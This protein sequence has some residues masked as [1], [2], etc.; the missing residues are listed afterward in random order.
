MKLSQ[1]A[2]YGSLRRLMVIATITALTALPLAPAH[3]HACTGI[4][5]MGKDGTVVYGRTMEW[6]A[7]DLHSRV[8]IVPRGLQ[9]V[10][11]TPDG[12]PGVTWKGK[13]GIVGLDAVNKEYIVDGINEK[14]LAAGLFYHPGFAVYAEYD[15][16]KANVSMG[17]TDVAQ[18][19]LSQ[20]ATIAEAREVL[21]KVRVVAVTEP[22]LGF[23][24][25]L[26]F[27]ITEPDGKS[28]VVEFL[29][30][31]TVIYDNPLGVITN[32]PTFDW[33]MINLRNYVNLSALALP[34]K[35]IEEM[36][37]KPLGAGSGL[38]GL[39]GDFTPPSRFIR[40][41]AFTQTA[42][43]T[44][45]GEDVANEVFRILDNFNLPLASV[46]AS[47]EKK[48]E[49]M[50]SSTIWTSAY[51]TKNRV[52]YYHTQHNRRIRMV[53]MNKIDFETLTTTV[54]LPLDREKSQDI[55]DMTPRK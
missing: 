18:Y 2:G 48:D 43:P 41:V 51:D 5:L 10:G 9:F 52:L 7:F 45:G 19:V 16:S 15:A 25:P 53:D 30:G 22:A 38:I 14:G 37:F 49:T 42:R 8:A 24:P 23:S 11:Q 26:H 28:I 54:R 29:D 55:E 13:Y 17:P 32:A 6:G 20:C 21:G 35:K 33:H 50:K 46:S 1:R 12:K 31:K 27:M 36:D 40:A 34:G 3:L 4:M 44:E 47:D 39:P